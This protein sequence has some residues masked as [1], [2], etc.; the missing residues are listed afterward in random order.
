MLWVDQTNY[1][2]LLDYVPRRIVSLVPSQ[3]EYLC[4]LGLDEE[5]VGITKFC[6]HPKH[7][8]KTK[9]IIGGT[10][11]VSISKIRDLNPDLVIGNKEENTK[12]DIEA[13]REF[14]PVWLSDIFTLEDAYQMMFSLGDILDKKFQASEIINEIQA[15]FNGLRKVNSNINALYLIWKKP[16]IAVGSNTFINSMLN[17][18][19]INNVLGNKSRYP[20]VNID[21][22]KGESL[23][24]ILLS[25]EPYPFKEKDKME[26]EQLF[27]GIRIEIVNGE[28]FS[29][30]GSRLTKSPA[31]L[32]QLIDKINH[33]HV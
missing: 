19:T 14:C 22:L 2:I 23:N 8:K 5:L 30:Y 29:W 33:L 21:D 1:T 20:E 17:E 31:Y 11:N 9:T 6:V 15:K 4:D 13:I 25:S 3:T 12:E 24:L 16:F 32:N 26:L 28:L 10:K 7:L 18:C 27:P